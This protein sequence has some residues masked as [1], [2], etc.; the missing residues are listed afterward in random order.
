[1]GV[2]EACHQ[3][4]LL[5]SG[6]MN[7][8]GVIGSEAAGAATGAGGMEVHG[9]HD[10][11]GDDSSLMP[12]VPRWRWQVRGCGCDVTVMCHVM[13][14]AVSRDAACAR[15][16]Y[17][18]LCARQAYS[19][20]WCGSHC[21]EPRG[22][23]EPLT[24][25]TLPLDANAKMALLSSVV[26]GDVGAVADVESL[27]AQ[28]AQAVAGGGTPFIALPRSDMSSVCARPSWPHVAGPPF[29]GSFWRQAAGSRQT[30]IY[31]GMIRSVWALR[32]SS[33]LLCHVRLTLESP[34]P[35]RT[36]RA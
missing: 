22:P 26:L 35:W 31:M 2:L 19:P 33:H 20:L 1:M 9:M 36:M 34:E 21:L 17:S 15:Q 11:A 7:L 29:Q 4:V 3:G 32:C 23:P 6:A 12:V 16:A 28:V 5:A 14:R 27:S 30:E 25:L 10:S 18:P 8:S 24:C 13:P